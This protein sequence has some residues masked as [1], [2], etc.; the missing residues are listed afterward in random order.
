MKR[1]DFIAALGGAAVWPVVARAQQSERVR[2][3]GVVIAL[4]VGTSAA[5]SEE[6][7]PRLPR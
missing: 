7:K 6:G 1:R 3:I 4:F 2:R 5:S